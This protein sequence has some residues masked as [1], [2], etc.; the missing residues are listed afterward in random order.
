MRTRP[1]T[2]WPTLIRHDPLHADAPDLTVPLSSPTA[3]R[4]SIANQG[5]AWL[6]VVREHGSLDEAVPAFA[7]LADPRLCVRSAARIV[8]PRA[9][10]RHAL[11]AAFMPIQ[12][13][14]LT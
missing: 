9:P 7:T 10:N 4:R 3:S 13:A 11:G 5:L 1:S 2:S 8:L 6:L 12:R 14:F